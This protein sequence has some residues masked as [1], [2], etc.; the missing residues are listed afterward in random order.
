MLGDEGVHRDDRCLG[1]ENLPGENAVNLLIGVDTGVLEDD[2]AVIQVERA[3]QR[4]E[5]EDEDEI[6]RKVM[7]P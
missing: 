7:L 3:P 2:A 1:L 4:G 5:N 6:T